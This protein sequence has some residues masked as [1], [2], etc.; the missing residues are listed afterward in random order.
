MM[1]LPLSIILAVVKNRT[2]V[3]QSAL[4]NILIVIK[5][6]LTVTKIYSFAIFFALYRIL[7]KNP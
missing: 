3:V 4:N 6:I 2:N 5:Y 1:S 7:K